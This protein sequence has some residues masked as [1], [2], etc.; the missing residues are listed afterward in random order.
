MDFIQDVLNWAQNGT[1]LLLYAGTGLVAEHGLSVYEQSLT[2]GVLACARIHVPT[3]LF[4]AG[5]ETKQECTEYELHIILYHNRQSA[6][7]E[8]VIEV[9]SY[10]S[11]MGASVSLCSRKAYSYVRTPWCTNDLS[12]AY[13]RS[14]HQFTQS[15]LTQTELVAMTRMAKYKNR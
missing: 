2:T 5:W 11:F 9:L 14:I 10:Q 4:C 1:A 13:A 7:A 3:C 15:S 12:T 6:I 8:T